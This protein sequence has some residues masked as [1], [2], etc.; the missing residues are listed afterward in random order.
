[1]FILKNQMT[2]KYCKC[3]RH[4]RQ[5]TMGKAAR[6]CLKFFNVNTVL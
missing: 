2:D 5:E 1:M 6:T 4:N 3:G